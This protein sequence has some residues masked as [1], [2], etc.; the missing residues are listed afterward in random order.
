[1]H[2]SYRNRE[3]KAI[4]RVHVQDCNF[5]STAADRDAMMF[6]SCSLATC[7]QVSVTSNRNALRIDAVQNEPVTEFAFTDIQPSQWD[8]KAPTKVIRGWEHT[9]SHTLTDAEIDAL[10]VPVERVE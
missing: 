6:S 4:D 10:Y 9:T 5:Q 2:P 1:M 7:G 8:W 3:G